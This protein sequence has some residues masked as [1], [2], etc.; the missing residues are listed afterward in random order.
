M[1]RNGDVWPSGFFR[2]AGDAR[3]REC[4]TEGC[5]QHVS[6]RIER[7]GIGSEHCEPCAKKIGGIFEGAGPK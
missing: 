1:T 2:L 7:D 5:Y 4:A 3:L 6:F